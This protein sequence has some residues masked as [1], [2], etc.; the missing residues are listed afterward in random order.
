MQADAAIDIAKKFVAAR[1]SGAALPD[2]PGVLPQGL[3]SAYAI[4]DAAI[5]RFGSDSIM[6]R[7][8]KTPLGW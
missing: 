2:Y 5:S 3:E 1:H 4:Q 6:E 7:S 8:M